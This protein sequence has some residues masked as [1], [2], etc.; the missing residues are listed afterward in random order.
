MYEKQ[1][2][3]DNIIFKTTGNIFG[4][5]DEYTIIKKQDL[6]ELGSS[7]KILT[8]DVNVLNR[9]DKPIKLNH[10]SE[11]AQSQNAYRMEIGTKSKRVTIFG[12]D[13]QNKTVSYSLAL[14]DKRT[15]PE[16]KTKVCGHEMGTRA[17]TPVSRG[18]Y[19]LITKISERQ[20]Q[21]WRG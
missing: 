10:L 19:F 20:N 7:G 9:F 6:I 5:P 11:S 3:F 21:S 13:H 4:A 8:T 1:N 14:E 18:I 15:D 17:N 12:K 2:K 16:M